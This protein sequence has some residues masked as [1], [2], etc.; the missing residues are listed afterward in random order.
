MISFAVIGEPAPEGSVRALSMP[1]KRFPVVVHDNP[2]ALQTW[3]KIVVAGATVALEDGALPYTSGEAVTVRI[4]FYLTRPKSVSAKKRPEPTVRPDVDKLTRAVLDALTMAGVY[5]DD[6]QV[7]ALR[8]SKEYV[9][10]DPGAL[11]SI[12]LTNP[13]EG[14]PTNGTKEEVRAQA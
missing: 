8:V 13:I 14:A 7:C 3:R 9:E 11:V 2:K 12:Y 5:A 6:A 10:L 4:S 1:G